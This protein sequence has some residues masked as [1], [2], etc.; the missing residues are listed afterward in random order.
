MKE[1]GG[2]G[3][4]EQCKSVTTVA[5]QIG[6]NAGESRQNIQ[7][8]STYFHRGRVLAIESPAIARDGACPAHCCREQKG[9]GGAATEQWSEKPLLLLL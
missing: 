4:E 6:V 8:F 9:G 3:S 1:G 7:G 5:E 2:G